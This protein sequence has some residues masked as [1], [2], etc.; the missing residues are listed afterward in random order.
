MEFGNKIF[1]LRKKENL[2]Q[3]E[4]AEKLDVSR[5]TISKWELGETNPNIEQAKKLAKIFKIS[6]DELTGNS[7]EMKII[8]KVTSTERFSR[9]IVGLSIVTTVFSSI[10]IIFFVLFIVTSVDYFKTKPISQNI[11][12][13]CYLPDSNE[14]FDYDI[15]YSTGEEQKIIDVTGKEVVPFDEYDNAN[16]LDKDITDYYVLLGGRCG[17]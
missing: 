12:F 11:M 4:L 17:Q 13:S 7:L 9:I 6:L 15:K 14:K 3:E 8:D 5:Q 2:S 1:E 10:I 16:D